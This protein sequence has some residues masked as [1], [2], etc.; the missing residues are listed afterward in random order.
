MNSIN[1]AYPAIRATAPAKAL[2]LPF[3]QAWLHSFAPPAKRQA[4]QALPLARGARH[5]VRQPLGRTVTC[6]AGTLWL[7]FD[8][9]LPD[10]VLE[11]GESH[12]CALNT[13]LL[14]YALEAARVRVT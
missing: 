7:T 4:E 11:A 5:W 12:R 3:I 1:L 14:V 2:G 10:I 8:H 13:A 6:E 9:A